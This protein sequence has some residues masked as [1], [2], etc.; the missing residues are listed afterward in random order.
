VSSFGRE[1]ERATPGTGRRR[2][3]LTARIWSPT[4]GG[5]ASIFSINTTTTTTM[6]ASPPMILLNNRR[7]RSS[8]SMGEEQ[9]GLSVVTEEGTPEVDTGDLVIVAVDASDRSGK[10]FDC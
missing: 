1:F 3:H 8:L 4:G 7:M 6:A 5:V 10:V 2:E 9:L